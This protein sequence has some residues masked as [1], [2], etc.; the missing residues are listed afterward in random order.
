VE[1]H[2]HPVPSFDVADFPMPSGREEV[3]RFAP[4]PRFVALLREPPVADSGA[5]V[6]VAHDPM[7]TTLGTLAPG[8]GAR[9]TAL[10]PVDR[11]SALAS[12]GA[13]QAR[14][15]HIAAAAT[16]AEPIVVTVTG[17]GQHFAEHLVIEAGAG[18][19]ATVVVEH[20]G[21]ALF[22]G[23]IEVIVGDGAKLSVVSV[24]DWAADAVHGGMHAATVGRD[25]QYRHVMMTFGGDA[26]RIQN[27]VKYAGPGGSA[28]LYGL[29]FTDAGQYQ[30]HRLFVD[31]NA[32]HTTSR[33]DY[34]GALQGQGAHSVWVGDVLIRRGANDIDSYEANKNLVLTDGCRADSVPNLEIET[35]NIKGAGHSSTTGRFDDE[36]LFYLMSRGLS[37]AEARRLVVQGFFYDIIRRIGVPAL[38]ERL[39]THVDAELAKAATQIE[40][41]E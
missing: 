34:R 13:T 2:L 11:A 19:D 32:P 10:V 6:A 17:A 22:L 16:L 33:V 8:V 9:G 18:C 29:Y 25:A 1:S 35:G 37:A 28:E 23:N 21:S 4:L 7:N 41:Q 12:G 38:E 40:G 39:K 26:V 5:A 31:Q 20:R 27:C 15:I 24:Q 14:H 30:E 36:Q 3:W